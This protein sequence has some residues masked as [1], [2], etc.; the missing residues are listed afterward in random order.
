MSARA[1]PRARAEG[2]FEKLDGPGGGEESSPRVFAVDAELKGVPASLRIHGGDFLARGDAELFAHEV[3]SR[4]L[5]G[6]GVL[7]LEARVDFEERDGAVL[8]HEKLARARPHVVGFLQNRFGRFDKA[9][10][11]LVAQKWCRRLLDE[12]LVASTWT[13]PWLSARH[14]VSTWRGASR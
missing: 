2:R 10:V 11:L 12:F 9:R 14:C 8:T 6:H 1:P 3:D 5:F 13:L 7:D 4:D